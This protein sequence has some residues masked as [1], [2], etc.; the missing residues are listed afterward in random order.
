[1]DMADEVLDVGRAGW[2]PKRHV[3]AC[4]MSRPLRA[5]LLPALLATVGCFDV[6]RVS[7]G[8]WVIDDFEDGDFQPADRNLGPWT[9][10]TFNPPNQDCSRSLESGDQSAYSLSLDFTIADPADG[11]PQYGSAV[12]QTGIPATPKSF[13]HFNE[14]VFSA[15]LVSG[16]SALPS[17]IAVYVQLGCSAAQLDDGT[18]PGNPYVLAAFPLPTANWQTFTLPMASFSSPFFDPTHILGGPAA[19]L[20]RVDSVTFAVDPNLDD[21]QTTMGQLNVDEIYF[22]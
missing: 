10:Y 14:M 13:L 18:N 3:P 17:T 21:G 8:P 2:Q 9:C 6:Q 16:V 4:V 12:L 1:M 11:S 15:K 20:Q 22:Q 5:A 7:Q 19:C